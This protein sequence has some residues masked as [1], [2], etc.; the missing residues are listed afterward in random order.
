V[1]E[2]PRWLTR[3]FS[4]LEREDLSVDLHHLHTLQKVTSSNSL[5][6]TLPTRTDVGVYLLSELSCHPLWTFVFLCVTARSD[7]VQVLTIG[8]IS[9]AV[10]LAGA[11]YMDEAGY[12]RMTGIPA[13]KT[14]LLDDKDGT[15]IQ[16]RICSLSSNFVL[17]SKKRHVLFTCSPSLLHQ[18]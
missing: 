3:A 12:A 13:G 5:T 10:V 15:D 8:K 4:L 16:V 6:C 14:R 2:P 7:H 1:A 11:A 18:R 9:S 17:G